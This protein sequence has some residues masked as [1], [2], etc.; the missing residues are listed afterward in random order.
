MGRNV[1]LKDWLY[2]LVS[3]A[4]S[5]YLAQMERGQEDDVELRLYWFLVKCSRKVTD[6]SIRLE[7]YFNSQ[8]NAALDRRS[9]C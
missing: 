4:A 3:V 2:L 1:S 8:M 5:Y 6:S 7:K 9:T